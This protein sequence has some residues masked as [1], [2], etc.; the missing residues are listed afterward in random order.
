MEE[1]FE[2]TRIILSPSILPVAGVLL[3]IA[4]L[5]LLFLGDLIVDIVASLLGILAILLG[6]GFLAWGHFV[7]RGSLT[8]ILLF[9]TGFLSLMVGFLTF[10]RRDLILDLVLFLGAGIAILAG[11][12][13]LLLGG[14]LSVRG[15]ARRLILGGGVLFL[16]AGI[17]LSLFPAITTRLLLSAAGVVIAGAGCAALFSAFPRGRDLRLGR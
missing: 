13:L 15:W 12:L 14:I 6:I 3:L 8:R 11:L 9:I 17:A 10:L 1:S 16:A 5:S 7:G 2:E 4:G